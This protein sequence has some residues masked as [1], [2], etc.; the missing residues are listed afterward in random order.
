MHA[1]RLLALRVCMGAHVPQSRGVCVREM[2]GG[3]VSRRDPNKFF[4][5]KKG[6]NY[7]NHKNRM[8]KR[9]L[10]IEYQNFPRKH[11]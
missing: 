7:V 8:V 1:L 3:S 9:F 5:H 4:L 10:K 2:V 6:A 11:Q